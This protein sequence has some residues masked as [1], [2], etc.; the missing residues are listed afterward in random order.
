MTR[1][2]FARVLSLVIG[3]LTFCPSAAPQTPTA[4]KPTAPPSPSEVIAA[5]VNG[6]KVTLAELLGRL[7]ELGVA[8]DRREEYAA[9]VLDGLVDNLLLLQFMTA[10][11]IPYDAKAVEAEL[12]QLKADY[13]KQGQKL[14][15]VLARMGLTEQKLRAAAIAEA[16]WHNYLAKQ[17]TEKQLAEYFAKFREFFD[18]TEVRASHILIEITPTASEATRTAAKNRAETIRREVTKKGSD[19]AAAAK[20]HSDCP[21]KEQGGDVG[22][23]PRRG[24]MV[25]PF[26]AAAFATK[27]GEVTPVVES[28]FGYH[29]I[30][31]TGRKPG[32]RT[33]L[34]DPEL[35]KDLLESYGEQLKD[36]IAAKQRKV[37]KIE[38]A[39]G[40]PTRTA[41]QPTNKTKK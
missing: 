29:V 11:K 37:A 22:W 40:E 35:R 10:Q 15:E 33:K 1:L 9:Q 30:L 2:H 3:L 14:G 34:S 17:V 21:S 41:A 16:Q 4:K 20:K 13:E 6:E 5:T 18:G 25:E 24:K 32:T 19:F 31:V 28:E 38:I 23:F 27:P 39:P 36:E 7:D 8:P 26:S 12:A